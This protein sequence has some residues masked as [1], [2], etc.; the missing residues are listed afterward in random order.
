MSDEVKNVPVVRCEQ[1]SKTFSMKG[2]Q[3][4]ALADVSLEIAAGE[5]AV[6]RGKSGCGKSTLLL[7]LGG[8]QRPDRGSVF[9]NEHSLYAMKSDDRAGFR[10]QNIGY[11]FQQFHLIPYL[12]VLENVCAARL[13]LPSN[14]NST[15]HEDDA[16]L[17]LERVGLADRLEHKPSQLSIG[18]CQRVA[19]AR[20]L[21]NRPKLILADEPTGNLDQ[22]NTQVVLDCLR[23]IAR[24]G[25]AVVMVTHD[26]ASDDLAD[27]VFMIADGKLSSAKKSSVG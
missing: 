1:L 22:D 3:I 23:D 17:L 2:K 27:R 24:E 9:V 20:A 6:V 25:T 19:I 11:V 18:E 8:L 4:V 26:A 16:R 12:S 13:G 15:S 7:A 5:F 10:A 14:V 21:M